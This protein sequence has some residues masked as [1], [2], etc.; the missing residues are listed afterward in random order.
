[1]IRPVPPDWRAAGNGSTG[2]APARQQSGRGRPGVSIRRM[3]RT[4]GTG[5][6]QFRPRRRA[7]FSGK[8]GRPPYRLTS[9]GLVMIQNVM[10]NSDVRPVRARLRAFRHDESGVMAP[11]V[12]ILFVLMILVGGIAVDVA[13]YETRR[14]EIQNTLDRATLAAASM[15]QALA[16]VTVVNDWFTKADLNTELGAVTVTTGMNFKNVRAEAD[17]TSKNYFMSMLEIDYL[18]GVDSSQAEQRVTNVEIALVLDV[19]GSMYNQISRITNLK[20][21][22]KDFI[23]TVLDSDTENK[24]SI[25]IVP[26]NGQVNLGPTL[27]AKFNVSYPHSYPNSYCIDLPTSTFANTTLS[28]DHG[29]PAGAVRRRLVVDHAIDQLYRADLQLL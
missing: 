19:S 25:A 1:M 24:I 4:A 12:L 11:L 10:R 3:R 9:G 28:R 21:A 23:D 13:R 15:T 8:A 5:M 27:A 17:V 26:Y 7:C 6:P 16:P 14:V 22:A 29:L 20:T 18:Q 2:P